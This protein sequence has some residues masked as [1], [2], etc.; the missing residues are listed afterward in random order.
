MGM[1]MAEKILARASGRDVVSP[2]EYV[3]ARIDLA[4]AHESVAPVYL[5]LLQAGLSK[6]WDPDRIV[7]LL[8]HYVPACTERSAEIHKLVRKAVK[9]LKIKNYYGERAGICHQVVP[10]K[11]HVLPGM[12]IAGCDSHTTTYGA[13]G[14]A[15][16]GI[17]FS[18]TAYVFATGTL[19]FKVPSTIRFNLSGKFQETVS[20][21]DVILAIAGKYTSEVAQYKSVEFTGPLAEEMSLASRMTMSNMAIEIGAKFGFFAPDKKV[22]EF[23]KGRTTERYD[24]VTPDPDA[25][26]EQTYDFDVS[27]LEPQIAFPYA[28][29]N[30]R[31]VSEA[32]DVTIQQAFIGSCTNGR[33]EDLHCAA[34]ILRGRK[35]HPDVRLYITPSSWEVY[36]QAMKDGTLKTLIDAGGVIQNSSCGL[37]FGAQQGLLGSEE[38]CIAAINR[39]FQ[40]RMGSNTAKV[41]LASPATVAASSVE[42]RIADPRAYIKKG[43][44]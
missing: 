14:A 39:N 26:Y 23:L 34:D 18:E 37:C 16:T 11:G 42:G 30:V 33:L 41:F 40:G 3:T 9:D 5:N 27:T 25:K 17:G 28:V 20:S 13:F 10:E 44:V 22:V 31:P 12:L 1:T 2:G 19:W 43:G 4:M 32:G 24:M 15:S 29:D 7:V 21:K 8:D 6:V 35:V 36:G 38:N